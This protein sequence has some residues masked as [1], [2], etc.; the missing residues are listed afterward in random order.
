[1]CEGPNPDEGNKNPVTLVRTVVARKSAVQFVS[2]L[3]RTM[4]I[5]ATSPETIPTRLK[6]TCTRV[7]VDGVIP[8]IIDGVLS[9]RF[10]SSG[11]VPPRLV[12]RL[13][14]GRVVA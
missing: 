10:P 7:N 8:R 1:M 14:V 5:T 13:T 3:E 4:P 2:S 6:R 12:P 11:P 9:D